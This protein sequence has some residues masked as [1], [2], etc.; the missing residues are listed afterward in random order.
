MNR[1]INSCVRSNSC[2]NT[3]HIYPQSIPS[4]LSGAQIEA[5]IHAAKK[6]IGEKAE[7]KP[8]FKAECKQTPPDTQRKVKG[9]QTPA[10]QHDEHTL[11]SCPS[12]RI[13]EN[14]ELSASHSHWT[15]NHQSPLQ[16][17]CLFHE[18]KTFTNI[19]RSFPISEAEA[20]QKGKPKGLN[21][22]AD[23]S[24]HLLTPQIA[25][26]AGAKR[27]RSGRGGWADSP[28]EG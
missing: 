4:L 23:E 1:L 10:G 3:L 14:K 27:R 25:S 15:L 18:M 12:Q 5:Y 20:N 6:R 19:T 26:R 24:S 21:L 16:S 22:I 8:T 17:K 2:T 11:I 7:I 13:M 9:S 28:E